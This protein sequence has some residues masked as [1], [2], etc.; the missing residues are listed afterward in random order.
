MRPRSDSG[1]LRDHPGFA[2][3]IS[4]IQIS[5][6]QKTRFIAASPNSFQYAFATIAQWVSP[7]PRLLEVVLRR[8]QEHPSASISWPLLRKY[9]T[10]GGVLAANKA[11]LTHAGLEEALLALRMSLSTRFG[12]LHLVSEQLG[13]DVVS[14]AKLADFLSHAGCGTVVVD[15][16]LDDIFWYLDTLGTDHVAVTDF[17]GV[18]RDQEPEECAGIGSRGLQSELKV[19]QKHLEGGVELD[20][21]SE[22]LLGV[23][24]PGGSDQLWAGIVEHVSPEDSFFGLV[25]VGYFP[26]CVFLFVFLSWPSSWVSFTSIL[27]T[28]SSE[29]LKIGKETCS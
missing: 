1:V 4:I 11:N 19:N 28:I 6:R 7:W 29:N 3:T 26:S 14:F 27:L 10:R 21:W 9:F 18:A 25:V 15:G 22:L 16:T 12:G 8:V 24:P 5:G 2:S 13:T 20:N 17:L 23:P